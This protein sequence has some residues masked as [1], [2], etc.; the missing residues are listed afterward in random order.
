MLLIV[1]VED[2]LVRIDCLEE[3]HDKDN[4][5]LLSRVAYGNGAPDGP[6]RPKGNHGEHA[7][8][9]GRVIGGEAVRFAHVRDLK[10]ANAVFPKVEEEIRIGIGDGEHTCCG[11]VAH[12]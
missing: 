11:G 6:R 7:D 5:E 8:N 3:E 9:A 12:M 4:E 1:A 2:I 10:V